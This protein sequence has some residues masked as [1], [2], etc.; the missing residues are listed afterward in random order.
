MTLTPPGD[1]TDAAVPP[2]LLGVRLAVQIF[3]AYAVMGAWVPVFSLYLTKLGFSPGATAWASATSAI[4]SVIAPLLW[5]QIADRWLAMERCISLCAAAT[6]LG[7]WFLTTLDEP[8]EVFF[9]CVA[10]WFFLIP[11]IG[12]TSSFVFRQLEHPE[13]DFGKIRMWG[14]IG[15]MAA[16]WLLTWWFA[17][18]Q[19]LVGRGDTVDFVDS[20][21]LGSLAAFVVAVYALT[22]PHTPPG[23]AAEAEQSWLGHLADAPLQALRL[24]RNRSCFVYCGCFFGF[25]I[26][27]PF[28]IQLN[29][30]LLGREG[31]S[32]DM[33][34]ILLTIAQSTEVVSLFLLPVL[35]GRFG[36]KTVMVI[37]CAMWTVGLAVLGVGSLG[38]A[39]GALATHGLFITCF[40]VT[41][42]VFVNRQA[43]HAIRA[44]VQGVLVLVNGAGLLFGNLLVGWIRDLTADNFRTAYLAAAGLAGSLVLIFF[45]GFT[46]ASS[47]A[48]SPQGSLV[49]DSE[50]T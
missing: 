43:T 11:L 19:G 3:L 10:V 47:S 30:L 20:L 14:T 49:P 42:Q 7:L 50:R 13:R 2:R 34:P 6:G 33:K 29:P 35:L 44:S 25:Y 23:P 46:G 28:T 9:A 18:L 22:L 15:W 31:I 8:W 45:F 21:H 40:V 36:T 39:L 26:T 38:F 17:Q 4:G 32:D 24:F 27:M 48:I 1:T 41:G 16:N 37:G 5:G 12:L